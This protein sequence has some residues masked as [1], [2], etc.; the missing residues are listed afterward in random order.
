M[1]NTTAWLIKSLLASIVI[2]VICIIIPVLFVVFPNNSAQNVFDNAVG[3]LNADPMYCRTDISDHSCYKTESVCS[4]EN[5]FV[6]K[7]QYNAYC[8]A[9]IYCNG[10][11]YFIGL[12]CVSSKTEGEKLENKITLDPR[13]NKTLDWV[14]TNRD[15]LDVFC[16]TPGGGTGKVDRKNWGPCQ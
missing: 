10:S 8:A 13:H 4:D 16:N 1:T 11:P 6:C 9:D 15:E 5:S 2:F 12:V 3:N 7:T 14:K